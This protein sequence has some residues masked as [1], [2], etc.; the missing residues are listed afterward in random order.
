MTQ[1]PFQQNW[2]SFEFADALDTTFFV[3]LSTDDILRCETVGDIEQMVYDQI[4]LARFKNSTELFESLL[5]R[6]NATCENELRSPITM[7]DL[8]RKIDDLCRERAIKGWTGVYAAFC[9]V[10][11]RAVPELRMSWWGKFA[12]TAYCTASLSGVIALIELVGVGIGIVAMALLL[13]CLPLFFSVLPSQTRE[14]DLTLAQAL[15]RFVTEMRSTHHDISYP[16][17]R[18]RMRNLCSRFFRIDMAQISDAT[19]LTDL[20]M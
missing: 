20:G 9:V 10:L 12:M 13:I 8:D 5:V 14:S 7:A 2:E 16:E 6:L 17:V 11:A 3:R 1:K 4:T 19:R 18:Y 15:D